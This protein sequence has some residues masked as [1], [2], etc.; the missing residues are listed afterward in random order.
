[1][2]KWALIIIGVLAGIVVLITIIGALLPRDHVASTSASIP[3][4]PEDVWDAITDVAAAPEWRDL[5]SVEVL[6]TPG[7]P[8]R[9]RE[10]SRFG[11]ITLEQEEAIPHQR[12]VG[13]IAD[14]DQGF[15]GT[16]TY[17]IEP[18]ANGS[19]VTIT[20]RGFV[21]NPLFRFMSRFVF[22]YYGTQE[23]YL[24]ALGKKFGEE[25]VVVREL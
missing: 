18:L 5:K 1:M 23:S 20:E 7:K 16:W 12:F 6:S 4:V 8:L 19:R 22:G 3:A 17:E 9:W 24:R 15:G 14:T 21:T 13:R 11:P 2:M 25:V 10:V